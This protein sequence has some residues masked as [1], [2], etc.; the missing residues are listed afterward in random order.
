MKQALFA[1]MIYLLLNTW[2]LPC[3]G[4]RIMQGLIK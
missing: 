2:K 1:T 3:K 4:L